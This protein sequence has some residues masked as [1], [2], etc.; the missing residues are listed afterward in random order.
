MASK[1]SEK[2]FSGMVWK[3]LE[4]ILAQLVSFTVSVVLARLLSP[5][6]YG[7]VAMVTVFINIANIFVTSGLSTSLIQKKDADELDFS[8][9]FWCTL[10]LSVL[11]YGALFVGAS[12]IASFYNAPEL[13]MIVRV[14][15]IKILISAY[16]S[17]Q[18]SYV[19]RKMMFKK[20]FF[21]T[22]LGTITSGVVGILMALNGCGVWS[23]VAQYLVNSTIDTIVL[24]FTVP[25]HPKLVFS[26]QAAKPLVQFG[27]KVLVADLIGTIYNNLRQILIGHYYT[28]SDLA[29]YNKG[30]QMPELL[31]N[32]IDITVSSVL[33]PA[34]SDYADNPNKVRAVTRKSMRFTAYLIFPMMAGLAAVAKPLIILLLTEKWSTAVVY[35]QVIAIARA[36]N[37]VTNSNLQAMRALGRSD[38]VLKL[39]FVKKPIGLLMI[40]LTIPYGVL[41]VALT[42]PIYN[43][44]AA[45]INMIPNKRLMGYSLLDQVKDLAPAALL[46]LIMG[47]I[48]WLFTC[49]DIA[50]SV[51]LILQVVCGVGIYSVASMLFK[52]EE[53]Y[54]L[55]GFL[56]DKF[57][58]KKV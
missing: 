12:Y 14:F 37:T 56:N 7:T 10:L 8:T 28:S 53:W 2:V 27:W 49:L 17:I 40:F 33:F 39:E 13:V 4:R 35:L 36:L 15:S 24:G 30:K 23:I 51:M 32:N 20:F 18:H 54:Y 29:F 50:Y 41:W 42:L 19:S 43:L 58:N 57:S 31:S 55:K 45:V 44:I 9:V 48:I 34:M 52:V 5:E 6:H 38:I 16:N 46:S 47:A 21:S 3:F 22:L 11:I 1:D 25:W 26:M